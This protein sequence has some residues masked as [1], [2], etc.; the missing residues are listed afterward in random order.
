MPS[1]APF[2]VQFVP[3]Q[4]EYTKSCPLRAI[5]VSVKVSGLV[6]AYT[7][8]QLYVSLAPN[9]IEA[10]VR[11]PL[12]DN[13]VVL[14]LVVLQENRAIQ[15]VVREKE[16]AKKL[17]QAA[18]S[19][20]QRA[21]LAEEVRENLLLLEVSGIAP[22]IPVEVKLEVASF[23]DFEGG[24]ASLIFPTTMTPRYTPEGTTP[25][26][27]RKV[28]PPFVR[29]EAL[30]GI[31]FS[32]DIDAKAPISSIH[33]DSHLIVIER[34]SETSAKVKLKEL[35][36]VP[37]KDILLKWQVVTSLEE[38]FIETARRGEEDAATLMISLPPP[39]EASDEQIIPRQVIFLLDR[40]GSM[41]GEPIDTA[42]RALR[43]FLR[44]LGQS[45]QFAIIAFD[46]ALVTL[47]PVAF[48]DEA[49]ARAD[50]FIADVHAN[51]GTEILPA[52][53]L[54]VAFE[55]PPGALRSVVL[56]TDGSVSNEDEISRYVSQ[57][58]SRRG[59]RAHAIGLGTS[60]NRM[61][62]QKV[63]RAGRGLAEF[64][65]KVAELEPV[66]ARFQ[67]R[68]GA[69]LATDVSLD[70][71]G[72]ATVDLSPAVLGDVDLGQPIVAFARALTPGVTTLV[73]RARLAGKSLEKRFPVEVPAGVH[74]NPAL[75]SLWA[76]AFIEE[77]LWVQPADCRDQVLKI[78]LPHQIVTPYTS[79]IAVDR[80]DSG[81]GQEPTTVE[82]PLHLPEG[83]GGEEK[84]VETY[85]GAMPM[86]ADIS[87]GS[88]DMAMDGGGGSGVLFEEEPE[89][90]E[91]EDDEEEGD[92][93]E[94]AEEPPPPPIPIKAKRKPPS[95]LALAPSSPDSEDF[96]TG[97]FEA[98]GSIDSFESAVTLEF[99]AVQESSIDEEPWEPPMAK[100]TP[101][102]PMLELAPMPSASPSVSL[103]D[104]A[105]EESSIQ[106]PERPK[107]ERIQA[108]LRYLARS[109][110]AS[111]AFGDAATT[112]LVVK[113]FEAAGETTKK[114][115]YRRQLSRAESYLQKNTAEPASAPTEKEKLLAAQHFGGDDDGAVLG[116]GDPL[117]MT[118]LLILALV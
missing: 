60:V 82:I 29:G 9:P 1:P 71:E 89:P 77:L 20:G 25:D 67:A 33:S 59:V 49:L 27:V 6:A 39:A 26:D 74:G 69:P 24:E 103:P 75:P 45:D 17:Y 7:I 112:A 5:D 70:F 107:E 47:P 81:A 51:G 3:V 83:M 22:N 4:P 63:A 109:Q 44:S 43:G 90:M 61:L 64:V 85:S 57:A 100:K 36:V 48:S 41:E 86:L 19:R 110:S 93:K 23:L 113:A 62:I 18:R 38:P 88:E 42:K 12:P 65:P 116:L 114:G 13:A 95:R 52:L 117:L 84:E 106:A 55:A 73:L 92:D 115:L 108:A 98:E 37:E 31:S 2:I 8:R 87:D 76:R 10:V 21:A 101:D 99:G 16:Q 97:E 118:A 80:T 94:V 50:K 111:G 102:K 66:L 68:S 79:L 58:A 56:L 28:S 46:D 14:S 54:A 96:V 35:E 91:M 40:S 15:A 105:R 34:P 11:V 104:P 72:G 32:V 30:Y 53:E 78:A